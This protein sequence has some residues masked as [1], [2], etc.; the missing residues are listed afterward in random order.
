LLSIFLDGTKIGEQDLGI[1]TLDSSELPLEIGRDVPG[2]TEYLNGMLDEIYI[3]SRALSD[4]EILARYPAYSISGRVTN[5]SGIGASSVTLFSSSGDSI[6]TDAS[7]YYTITNVVTGTHTITPTKSGYIFA[8]ITRTVS[9]PPSSTGND[10]RIRPIPTRFLTLPV[11]T[12]NSSQDAIARVNSWFDHQSP[13][14]GHDY[15]IRKWEGGTPLSYPPGPSDDPDHFCTLQTN[16]YGGHN[17][18]DFSK[19]NP[20]LN[21]DEPVLAAYSGVVASTLIT[22]TSYG[23]RVWIN[24]QNGYAT[25]YGHLKSISVTVNSPINAGQHLGIMGTTGRSTGIHLHFGLYYDKDG[26]GQWTEDEVVDPYGWFGTTAAWAWNNPAGQFIPNGQLWNFAILPDQATGPSGGTLPSPSG[27]GNAIIP[28]GALTT[29]LTIRFGDVSPVAVPSA[30]LR[31][32]GRSFLLQVLE[33]LGISQSQSVRRPRSSFAQPVT[34]QVTYGTAETRHFDTSQMKIYYWNDTTTA[35]I[36][37]PT[38]VDTNLKTATA[39]TTEIGNFDLQAPLLC[40]AD[41]QEIDDNYYVAKTI[42]TDG[43]SANR[44][45]DIAQDEDW[46]KLNAVAGQRYLIQTGNLASG[47]DTVLQ[48]YDLDGVTQLAL[49]DNSGGGKASR[50]LWQAPQTGT[51]FVRVSQAAGSAFGCSASIFSIIQGKVA[52]VTIFMREKRG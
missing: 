37:L 1:G 4:A 13:D 10:F 43:V 5:D 16:C 31:T 21:V 49:D 33:W 2:S 22:N 27:N 24:H 11:T 30:Q 18:I 17:G 6:T 12:T 36:A 40:P 50:L 32:A 14:Y 26:N 45:F 15:Q 20:D 34:L 39:Q 8:P 44:L 23:N 3:Y 46:L 19:R 29:T 48:V 42:T 41:S 9:V 51:Y 7:G 35:W 38:T 25:L 47:V 52:R 28:S